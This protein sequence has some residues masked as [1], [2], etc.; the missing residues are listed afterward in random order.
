MLKCAIFKKE[1]KKILFYSFVMMQFLS[2]TNFFSLQKSNIFCL[3]I[4][5]VP[6]FMNC[7][8]LQNLVLALFFT[9]KK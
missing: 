3:K 5:C 8:F 2:L 1:C 9:V 7:F 6:C 4:K